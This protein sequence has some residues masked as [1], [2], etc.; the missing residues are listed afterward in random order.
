VPQES[1]KRAR[2]VPRELKRVSSE[3]QESPR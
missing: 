3:L 1:P 2:E